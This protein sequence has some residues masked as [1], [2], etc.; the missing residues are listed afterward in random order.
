MG[1][2]RPRLR[3]LQIAPC[4]FLLRRVPIGGPRVL[5]QGQH[6]FAAFLSGRLLAFEKD[7][8]IEHFSLDR[9]GGRLDFLEQWF[10]QSAH[11]ISVGDS[12]WFPS[13]RSP[14]M[15]PAAGSKESR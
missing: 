12:S 5:R 3:R 6:I 15:P 9:L 13:R 1:T 11:G 10:G 4:L 2:A 7:E 8:E 14:S